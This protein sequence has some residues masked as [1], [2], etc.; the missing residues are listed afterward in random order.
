MEVNEICGNETTAQPKNTGGQKQCLE[1]AMKLYALAK[2]TFSF[3]SVAASKT[4]AAWDAAKVAKDIV[5]FYDIEELADNET[6]AVIKNG[7]YK[8]YKIKSAI[9]GA[10]YTHYLS[11]CSHDAL[12]SYEDSDYTR[13]FRITENNEI[14]C[15]VNDDGTVS[16]APLTSMLVGVRKDAPVDG[17]AS[18]EVQFKYDDFKQSFIVP[19]FD[20]TS[21]EGIYDVTLSQ[22]SATSSSI[23][24]K[25]NRS[26]SGSSVRSFVAANFTVK[27]AAGAVQ[28]VSFVAPDADGNYELTGTGFVNGFTVELNGVIAQSQIVYE[29]ESVLTVTG[30]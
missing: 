22:V 15:E 23:R 8:D 11:T 26:C 5:I 19:E 10:T 28:T 6:A 25:A 4:K 20:A 13:Q 27:D 17:T 30:I 12:A 29:G 9:R 18:T 16:G 7:R 24:V 3:A 1:G 14:E 21:L 2:S